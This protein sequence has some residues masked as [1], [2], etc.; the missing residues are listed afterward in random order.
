M[1]GAPKPVEANLVKES[2]VEVHPSERK[3]T[4]EASP[5]PGRVRRFARRVRG[6][7]RHA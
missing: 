2:I 5:C 3:L 7:K 4:P 6:K 1:T